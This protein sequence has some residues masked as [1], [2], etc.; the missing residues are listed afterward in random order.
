MS[1]LP[2]FSLNL[3][4]E[5]PRLKAA[6]SIE[7]VIHWQ[8]HAGKKLE[9]EALKAELTQRLPDYP[10]LQPQQDVQIGAVGAPDGSSEVFQRIQWSGFRLQDEQN[11]HV[12]QFTLNGVAFSRLEPYEEWI[13]FQ[14]EAF[15]FWHIFLELA[16]PTV[17]QRLGVRYI[18]RIPLDNG[19]QPSLYLNTVPPAPS[20]LELPTE[21]FFHQDTYRVPG[22]PYHIN[23][24]RTI[25]PEG[26][27]PAN[28][29]ALIVDIDVFTTELLQL[30]QDTLIQQLKEM[31]WLKNKVFFSCI[32][33][34]ALARFGATP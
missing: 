12:A 33:D 13:S 30:D 32:T 28:G 2:K 21:S 4:E 34:T 15:R 14:T 1:P 18:N 20:G 19:E 25:Q 22:Y 24:V 3:N 17:I 5:F 29:R 10:I 26:T 23:W 7:A 9:S 27:D 8:A 16:E 31:R 6:P 11:R